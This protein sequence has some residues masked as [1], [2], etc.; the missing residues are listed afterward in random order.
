MLTWV[1]LT[2]LII[3]MKLRWLCSRKIVTS[4]ACLASHGSNATFI[5]ITSLSGIMILLVAQ[6][7]WL[8]D[9]FLLQMGSTN[10]FLFESFQFLGLELYFLLY[11]WYGCGLFLLQV[12]NG[13]NI[14]PGC[15]CTRKANEYLPQTSYSSQQ[16]GHIWIGFTVFHTQFYLKCL[17]W[18]SFLWTLGMILIFFLTE[19]LGNPQITRGYGVLI[20]WY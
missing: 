6:F 14:S 2:F 5:S 10:N 4:L 16:F 1:Y 12:G 15:W 13:N 20:G 3:L 11:T 7:M 18:R 19:L 8:L 17:S 9:V